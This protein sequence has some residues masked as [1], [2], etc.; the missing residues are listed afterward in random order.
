MDENLTQ[1]KFAPQLNTTFR[2]YYKPEEYLDLELIEISELRERRRQETFSLLFHGPPHIQLLQHLFKVEHD[3]MGTFDL[4]LVP[5]AKD[6][7]GF[8]YEAV[9]NRLIPAK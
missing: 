4:F 3:E 9:F 2:V 6:E 1:E 5:V 8:Q 7:E